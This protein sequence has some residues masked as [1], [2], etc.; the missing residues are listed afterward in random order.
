MPPPSLVSTRTFC[1]PR[2]CCFD[3]VFLFLLSLTKHWCRENHL[4]C[5]IVFSHTFSCYFN[6]CGCNP[7]LSGHSYMT[8]TNW[9]MLACLQSECM[10]HM[11]FTTGM[12]WCLRSEP[13]QLLLDALHLNTFKGRNI[14]YTWVFI[15]VFANFNGIVSLSMH[16]N[17]LRSKVHQI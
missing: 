5:W 13:K 10:E 6:Q 15:S 2:Q 11:N 12:T 1:W 17:G 16:L 4:H 14:E 3:F 9:M 7:V 8:L